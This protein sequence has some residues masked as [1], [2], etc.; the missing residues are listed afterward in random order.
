[1]AIRRQR[2]DDSPA[3]VAFGRQMRRLREAKEIKQETIDVIKQKLG[4]V[5]L[6]VYSLAAPRRVHPKTGEV[7]SSVIKPIGSAYSNKTV[8]IHTGSVTNITVEPATDEEIDHTIK[9]MGG[10]DWL[11]WIEALDE[12]GVLA[13]GVKAVAYSYIGPELTYPIYREGTIGK[14]KDH[15]EQTAEEI[16]SRLQAKGG[17]AWISVNKA[18]VTQSSAAIPVVP[19]YIS[20][21]YKVMKD[22]QIHEGCIE[23]MQRLF[24][25]R[26]YSGGQVPT[27]AQRRIR[28]DDLEM[29]EDVQQLVEKRF[30]EVNSENIDQI[31]DIDGFR[32]DFFN[33]FGF[34][35]DGIDYEQEVDPNVS[36]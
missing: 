11:L 32:E 36:L 18:L 29:Q 33:I 20:L 19:L 35:I 7:F 1:M 24:A 23:Q 9:V 3:L 14:A 27:D 4:Q 22:K 6:I 10:E 21:L 16:N 13:E 8:D 31:A 25:E 2:P 17:G 12:A 26:L 15:L 28:I 5:D 30:S 34:H